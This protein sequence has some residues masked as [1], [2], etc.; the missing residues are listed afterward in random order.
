MGE[1]LH[2]IDKLFKA[3]LERSDDLP[4]D[5]VWENIDKNLDKKKVVSI[6][7]KYKRLKWVAAALLIFSVGMAMYA[8]RTRIKNREIVKEN[9]INDKKPFSNNNN[10]VK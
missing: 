4:S 9:K 1:H 2:N 7:E 5:E 10:H 3:A 8:I 6:S